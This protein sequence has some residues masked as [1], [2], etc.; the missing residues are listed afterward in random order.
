MQNHDFNE[1]S[2]VISGT[3]YI[4]H[5]A[6]QLIDGTLLTLFSKSL[7]LFMLCIVYSGSWL[8]SADGSAKHYVRICWQPAVQHT[9]IPLLVTQLCRPLVISCLTKGRRLSW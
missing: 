2:D 5:V 6:S 3:I 8:A 7:D 9:Y 4:L 1:K